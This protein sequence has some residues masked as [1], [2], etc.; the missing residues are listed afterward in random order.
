MPFEE[1]PAELFEYLVGPK[2]HEAFLAYQQLAL[3]PEVTLPLIVNWFQTQPDAKPDM[4]QARH[5]IA[6][7]GSGNPALVDEAKSQLIAGGTAFR[8]LL[9]K[10]LAKERDTG[11]K[12][13]HVQ[14]IVRK[15]DVVSRRVVEL[16]TILKTPEADQAIDRLLQ[17]NQSERTKQLLQRSQVR[18]KRWQN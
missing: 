12:K 4:A 3:T 16:L 8:E 5:W 15:I 1:T 18:R 11:A 17:S 7:L 6:A 2:E 9:Q 10:E 13:T 14:D